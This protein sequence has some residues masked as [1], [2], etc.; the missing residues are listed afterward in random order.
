MPNSLR[1]F[2]G[3]FR[4]QVDLK[5][6]FRSL[7]AKFPR[8]SGARTLDVEAVHGA[9]I[10]FYS[11]NVLDQPELR[12]CIVSVDSIDPVSIQDQIRKA[13]TEAHINSNGRSEDVAGLL[14]VSP[15]E[16]SSYTQ[17]DVLKL[18]HEFMGR[19]ISF[20]CGQSLL[21]Q[22]ILHSPEYLLHN[23]SELELYVARITRSLGSSDPLQFVTSQEHLL[24]GELA[25]LEARYVPPK[26][27]WTFESSKILI[28]PDNLTFSALSRPFSLQQISVLGRM[29]NSAAT[30]FA[31]RSFIHWMQVSNSEKIRQGLQDLQERLRQSWNG[32]FMSKVESAPAAE[33]STVMSQR[34]ILTLELDEEIVKQFAR[35]LSPVEEAIRT[36]RLEL[37]RCNAFVA[38]IGGNLPDPS[39]AD[40]KRYSQIDDIVR[41]AP[42]LFSRTFVSEFRL[43]EGDL[44]GAAGSH[45]LITAPAGYG[46][47]SYCKVS[48]IR[49]A[50]KLGLGSSDVIPMFVPLSRLATVP[51]S[52]PDVFADAPELKILLNDCTSPGRKWTI[53]LDGL[54][55]VANVSKRKE[56]IAAVRELLVRFPRA[57]VIVTS[58]T[59]V[60][61]PELDWL[62]R[63]DLAP[64]DQ[65]S[66]KLLAEK[67]LNT[68]EKLVDFF[69]QLATTRSL[70]SVMSIPLLGSLIL[71]V[72]KG[73]NRLPNNKGRLYAIFINQL[74]GGWDYSK[75]INRNAD[76]GRN[77]KLN[78][79][80]RFAGLLHRKHAKIGVLGDLEESVDAIHL[81]LIT[82]FDQLVEELIEDGLIQR[83]GA[84]FI[85]S[86][87]SF[88]EYLAARDLQDDPSG[89]RRQAA[90]EAL[91]TGDGWWGEVLMFYV[92]MTKRPDD[93][94]MWIKR[95]TV[96]SQIIAATGSEIES[97]LIGSLRE[98]NP[99]WTSKIRSRS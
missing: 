44:L 50:V 7:I 59:Y 39:S 37:D 95:S 26:F 58:R 85:F 68:S 98:A 49:E 69:S 28:D 24:V 21:D 91:L 32:A 3:S 33:R 64:L 54:D 93:M 4:S 2:A 41:E 81:N 22:F 36:L 30:I 75:S 38:N 13:F 6:A 77:L 76:Y 65:E 82:S 14:V 31:S 96:R 12:A 67:W 55:E 5:H 87:H 19:S 74:G 17:K 23:T 90:L 70:A 78:V 57:R 43:S 88:Q 66:V 40:F 18:T 83:S 56:L 46:K 62:T 8:V 79:L 34:S 73:G 29:L 16:C 61:G 51:I 94:E 1:E 97:L 25:S 27:G 9:D 35:E 99:N 60:S 42:A 10:L 84:D 47:S 15:H 71:A 63:V 80:T 72:Y 89:E 48:V 92:G 53:Y 11:P 52:S 86:H 20:L 45:F